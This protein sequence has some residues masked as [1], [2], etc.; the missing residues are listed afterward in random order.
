MNFSLNHS[1]LQYDF[2]EPG[3]PGP[4]GNKVRIKFNVM[5]LLTYAAYTYRYTYIIHTLKVLYVYIYNDR[6]RKVNREAKDRV[7][8]MENLVRMDI[9]ENLVNKD[10]QDPLAQKDTLESLGN[11]R[12]VLNILQLKEAEVTREK[13]EILAQSDTED[14]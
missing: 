6:V 8:L 11:A 7:V 4:K 3:Y 5:K 13:L 1:D 14:L 10:H 12:S 2:G 9:L